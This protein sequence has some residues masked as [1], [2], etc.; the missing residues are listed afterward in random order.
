[1][2]AAEADAGTATRNAE[3]LMHRRVIMQIVE[4]AVAPRAAPAIRFEQAF[5]RLLGTLGSSFT[6]PR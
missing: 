6:A 1:M 2:I 5:D 4:D 3:H